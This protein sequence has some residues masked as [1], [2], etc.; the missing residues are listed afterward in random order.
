MSPTPQKV[1]L[2]TGA[3]RGIGLAVAKRFL[4]DAGAWRCS[5]SNTNCCAT[6]SPLWR[7][8]GDTMALTCDVSDADAVAAAMTAMSR[9][10]GRLDPWSTMPASPCSR[11]CSRLPIR[12]G[13]GSWPSTS[14]GRSSAPRPPRR[15][16]ASMAAAPLSTS[17]RSRRCAPRRCAR[18]T[19]PARPGLRISPS[20]SPSNWHRSASRQRRR[21]RP[22]RNRDGESGSHRGN[23]RRL[24]RR[25]SAQPLWPGR[26]IGRGG[27]L[28][29]Q[30]PL[31]LHHRQILAV[32]GG[33]DAAGIGLPTLR[34]ERRNS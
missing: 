28:S 30:R 24:P 12:T 23:P 21:T 17:P 3:A 16:C 33:F 22:G 19:A 8:P 5:T 1:A 20:S 27:V 32:D 10:F 13:A 11:R 2:V 34:G 9:R 26:G 25:H 6:R 4:A 29:V 18:P 31:E 14:P 15:C 7:N